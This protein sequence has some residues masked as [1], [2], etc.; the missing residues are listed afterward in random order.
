VPSLFNHLQKWEIE[1]HTTA[2][3]THF[4]PNAPHLSKRRRVLG[5]VL[6]ALENGKLTSLKKPSIRVAAFWPG[7]S[8]PAEREGGKFAS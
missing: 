7:H 6:S 5:A 1:L 4:E 8:C 3:S 2:I